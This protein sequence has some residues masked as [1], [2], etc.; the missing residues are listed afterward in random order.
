MSRSSETS[1]TVEEPV[2]HLRVERHGID[3]I[4][5]SERWA[6][7]RDLCLMWAGASFQVEYF[8]YGVTLMTFGFSLSQAII[9]TVLG[10][11]S[12]FLLG[13]TSLQGPVAGTTAMTI[14]RAPF[15]LRGSRVIAVFN[16]L[17]QIGFETEG[18]FLVVLAGESLASEAGL[19]VGTLG[20]LLFLVG[21]LCIQL[22]LPFFGHETMVKVLKVLAVP[23]VALYVVVVVYI[24]PKVQPVSHHA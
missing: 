22:L 7:P 21:G 24:A 5:D 19:H 4:P 9:L 14:N 3:H 2:A 18:L 12:F 10:N 16:W 17:T 23:F 13:L 8:V 6:R 11:L 20:K 1:M 15:G